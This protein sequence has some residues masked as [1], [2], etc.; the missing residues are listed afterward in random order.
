M[1]CNCGNAYFCCSLHRLHVWLL[2]RRA[3]KQ[4]Q[5]VLALA[6]SARDQPLENGN[7]ESNCKHHQQGI[8]WPA[9]GRRSQ[10]S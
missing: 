1:H 8:A 7:A 2:T 4:L 6:V 9:A 5:R 10:V 3:D